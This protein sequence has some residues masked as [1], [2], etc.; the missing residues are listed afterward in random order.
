MR[1]LLSSYG[2]HTCSIRD[3]T[4][5]IKPGI[6][7]TRRIWSRIA[8]CRCHV[9]RIFARLRTWHLD[10]V[11]AKPS[12]ASCRDA[13]KRLPDVAAATESRL[14]GRKWRPQRLRVRLEELYLIS[15]T[16]RSDHKACECYVY[17]SVVT[18]IFEEKQSKSRKVH[19]ILSSINHKGCRLLGF[20]NEHIQGPWP[21][22][23]F[24]PIQFNLLFHA[25]SSG[26]PSCHTSLKS[27]Y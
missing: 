20:I 27:G 14:L 1:A 17:A 7:N 6:A 16:P 22:F 23:A 3:L 2:G 12:G 15:V 13:R 19:K 10:M 9:L 8:C 11:S 21:D 24:K 5:L 26:F 25:H 4:L 18:W